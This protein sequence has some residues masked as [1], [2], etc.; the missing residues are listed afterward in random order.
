MVV[1]LNYERRTSE[2]K[3][4][5]IYKTHTVEVTIPVT[6]N[7]STTDTPADMVAYAV[8]EQVDLLALAQK[9]IESRFPVLFSY[10]IAE[11]L[12][13]IWIT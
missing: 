3:D 11:L 13:D 9:K 2:M 12:E 10:N 8:L 5:P 1:K 6:I 4:K 7:I